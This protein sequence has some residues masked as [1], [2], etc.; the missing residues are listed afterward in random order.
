MSDI[1]P[2]QAAVEAAEYMLSEQACPIGESIQ[3]LLMIVADQ[4][5]GYF[6]T[7]LDLVCAATEPEK[8]IL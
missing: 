3:V 5:E 1:N 7:V 6:K 8:A 4:P 2:D